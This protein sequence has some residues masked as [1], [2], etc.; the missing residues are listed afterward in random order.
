M[1]GVADWLVVDVSS[2]AY[3]A[4]HTTGELTYEGRRTG[5]AFGVW[6]DVLGVADLFN[7]RRLVFCFDA[8]P[9]VRQAIYGPYKNK[10][11]PA[12]PE[13]RAEKAERNR[14]IRDLQTDAAMLGAVLWRDGYEAD[15]LIATA[16]ESIPMSDRVLVLGTDKDLFQLLGPRVAMYR[17][18]KKMPWYGPDQFYTEWGIPPGQ[19][20]DVLAL[21]GDETDDVPGIPGVGFKTACKWL[22][23][24][25]KPGSVVHGKIMADCKLRLAMARALVTLPVHGCP[26]PNLDGLQPYTDT[27]VRH[28]W[29]RNGFRSG[30]PTG[31]AA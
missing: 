10:R 3:R 18:G 24:E 30:P 1:V 8:P 16:I 23:G 5:V 13:E 14:A 7:I 31:G 6:R 17:L 12:T 22:R 11:V 27:G 19:W 2:L 20:A 9:T 25:I 26:V 21:A 28:V 15:D 4:W 29:G